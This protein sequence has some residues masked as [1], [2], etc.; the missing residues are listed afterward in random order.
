[1]QRAG[2]IAA[3]AVIACSCHSRTAWSLWRECICYNPP[4]MLPLHQQ[5][6]KAALKGAGKWMSC[7]WLPARWRSAFALIVGCLVALQKTSFCPLTVQLC[8]EHWVSLLYVS[9]MCRWAGK[10]CS[11][12]LLQTVLCQAGLHFNILI[13]PITFFKPEGNSP[14]SQASCPLTLQTLWI[15]KIKSKLLLLTVQNTQALAVMHYFKI[16]C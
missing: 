4:Q 7:L 9:E 2:I 11:E 6:F 13:F 3:S 1:M 5:L 14:F 16:A 8:T 10:W 12:C 15:H